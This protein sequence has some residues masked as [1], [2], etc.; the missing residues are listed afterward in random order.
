MS[1]LD[2]AGPAAGTIS[3][4]WWIMLAGAVAIFLL[5]VSLLALAFRR[6]EGG[7]PTARAWIV[8]GGLVFPSAVLLAL[9]AYGLIVGE[10]L[11]P[12]AGDGVVEVEAQASRWQWAFTHRLPDGGLIVSQNILHIPV[13]RNVDVVLTTRDVIHAF[14][15]PRLAGK[16]DAI[17]GH[18]NV[19]RIQAAAPGT[20]P[21]VCA[22]YCGVGH[23][24][25]GFVVRAHDEAGWAR[26]LAGGDS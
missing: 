6:G 10:R 19:L 20:Y 13:G 4:L 5:V 9:L 21:G 18:R 2:P 17:P 7:G 22:E 11:L 25:H 15:V 16:M 12:R 24:R 23:A 14:W 1:A 8:G 3:T 26:F